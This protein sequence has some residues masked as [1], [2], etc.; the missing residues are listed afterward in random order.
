MSQE[1]TIEDISNHAGALFSMADMLDQIDSGSDNTK[2]AYRQAIPDVEKILADEPELASQWGDIHFYLGRAY[3]VLGEIDRAID[4]LERSAACP[5]GLY[6]HGPDQMNIPGAI[7][8]RLALAYQQ[9]RRFEDA[10][11][12]F[13]QALKNG[14]GNPVY[15]HMSCAVSAITG[16]GM[17]LLSKAMENPA[18]LHRIARWYQVGVRH[19]LAVL[20]EEE[21]EQEASEISE[22]MGMAEPLLLMMRL[23]G[24]V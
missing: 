5:N 18:Q 8:H 13:E 3:S 4:H 15:A 23:F 7:H 20:D 24:L 10:V 22:L 2:D 14:C 12:Q 21:A 16:L 19:L 6:I 11:E 17:P 1:K 9:V